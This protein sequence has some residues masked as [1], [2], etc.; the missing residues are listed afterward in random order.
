L[1][2]R[3]YQHLKNRNTRRTITAR[4]GTG[5]FKLEVTGREAHAGNQHADGI[6]AIHALALIIPKIEALTD[7]DEGTTANAG[8]HSS[9]KSFC[10]MA[11]LAIGCGARIVGVSSTKSALVLSNIGPHEVS[12]DTLNMNSHKWGEWSRR[13]GNRDSSIL[14]KSG[15]ATARE[16]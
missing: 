10:T 7:Y 13:G 15:S 8:A 9:G 3:L 11:L 6:N 5:G 4:K 12:G 1:S 2:T 14:E 16:G